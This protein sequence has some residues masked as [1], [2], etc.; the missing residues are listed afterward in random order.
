MAFA[1]HSQSRVTTR[2]I[3]RAALVLAGVLGLSVLA[4][5][6]GTGT[7][8]Q[9]A[10]GLHYQ[11]GYYV[12][13]G[14]LCYGWSNGA[15]H[16]THQWH[17]S[18]HLLISNNPAW[19]PN[20]GS[21]SRWHTTSYGAPL[22]DGGHTGGSLP[23]APGHIGAWVYTGIPAHRMSDFAGDPYHGYFGACTW[24]AW[25]RHS[26]EPLMRLGNAAAWAWNAPRFG[27]RTGH[28]P[29]AGATV[30]F[31]PGVQGA[32]GLGHVAHVEKVYR[33]GWFLISEMSFYWNGGGWARVSYRYA[34]IGYGV[35]FIY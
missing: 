30:I 24:Y 34:H 8:A 4:T 12:D 5:Q 25:Y 23:A 7:T 32:S 29:V 1:S 3:A 14:W 19:V 26:R 20:Y 13:N 6:A 9:A 10:S 15:Y 2:G 22:G 33:N 27:L 17:R 21:N 28:A 16:C 11:R 18:G 31:Q 35:S